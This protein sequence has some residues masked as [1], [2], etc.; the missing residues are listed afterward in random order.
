LRISRSKIAVPELV[1]GFVSRSALLDRLDQADA[2]QLVVL[3]APPS[4]AA[5]PS[6]LVEGDVRL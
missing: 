4:T 5:S 6:I 3:V 1:A 2:G